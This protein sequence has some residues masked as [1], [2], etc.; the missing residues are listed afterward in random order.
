MLSIDINGD[1]QKSNL[2]AL[3]RERLSEAESN[4]ITN[5]NEVP[6]GAG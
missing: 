1:D 5:I 6:L 3:F 2:W 4:L